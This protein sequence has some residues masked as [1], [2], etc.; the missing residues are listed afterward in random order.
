MRRALSGGPAEMHYFHQA[1][2]PYSYLAAQC[3]TRLAATYRVA[4]VPHLV[5]APDDSAAPE[6]ARL[7]TYAL[8]DAM[9]VA[10]RYGLAF[11]NG[12]TAGDSGRLQAANAQLTRALAENR[13]AS[14]A[15]RIGDAFWSGKDLSASTATV[16]A[17]ARALAEGAAL[18]TK[19][20]HYLGAMF[21]FDGEWYWGVDRMHHLEA[22]LRAEDLVN[23]PDSPLIAPFQ[24]MRLDGRR[25]TKPPIIEFWFSYRSPYSY[26]AAPRLHHLADHYGAEVRLRFIMPMIMRGLP[27]PRAKSIYIVLDVKREA[28]ILGLRFGNCI[29]PFGAAIL[30]G[31]AVL[32]RA[33]QRG[34]GAEFAEAGL[35]AI[36]AEGTDLASDRGLLRTAHRAG[37]APADV[38]AALADESWRPLSEENRVALF[39]A[40]LWG[41][42]TYRV[43]GM[44]AH[45]G[46]DRLWALE[47]DLKTVIATE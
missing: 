14:D 41:A 44:P 16:D 36:F 8:R 15:A 45:W 42:P 13:F 27:V 39:E 43:N 19:L 29:D 25:A 12:A 24:E 47:E 30:R 22:R 17:T 9:R 6:R 38:Q 20:G 7:A 21:Y 31:N 28:E 3:L 32:H 46:Q 23:D 40:G 33:I 1:D 2:D 37:L 11:P 34:R 18:R 5:P 26:I 35:E 10:R 4:I